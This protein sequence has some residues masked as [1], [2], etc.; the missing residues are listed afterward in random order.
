MKYAIN[1]LFAALLVMALGACGDDA[2]I[3]LLE[4]DSA[5][6]D[7]IYVSRDALDEMR[8]KKPK[9]AGNNEET[10]M[11]SKG[12]KGRDRRERN[13]DFP[14]QD[15][16][17][18]LAEYLNIGDLYMV[19]EDDYYYLCKSYFPTVLG[20]DYKEYANS[21]LAVYLDETID[22]W[23]FMSLLAKYN[24]FNLNDTTRIIKYAFNNGYKL[25]YSYTLEDGSV[26]NHETM[27]YNLVHLYEIIFK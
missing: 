12:E 19:G 27:H 8:E 21:E 24:T 25:H 3:N 10:A 16:E 20:E 5:T 9:I 6:A 15:V 7:S 17:F 4:E 26:R 2:V 11:D 1:Y 14:D 13:E 23:N 18:K 22:N